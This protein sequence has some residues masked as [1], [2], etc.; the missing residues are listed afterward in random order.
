MKVIKITQVIFSRMFT[1]ERSSGQFLWHRCFY[2][3]SNSLPVFH[4]L[5]CAIHAKILDCTR[6]TMSQ[7]ARKYSSSV[8]FFLSSLKKTL[9]SEV[10]RTMKGASTVLINVSQD[11]AT[12]INKLKFIDVLL[13]TRTAYD[14]F[15]QKMKHTLSNEA[16]TRALTNRTVHCQPDK[17][18]IP[19]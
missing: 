6:R 17:K 13:A 18:N 3:R 11:G 16:D 1:F 14:C 5:A 19:Q 15:M 12:I 9:R 8:N 4:L 10:A 7:S 2:D